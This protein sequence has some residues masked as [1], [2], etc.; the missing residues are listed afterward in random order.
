MKFAHLAD[1][2]LGF[3]QY[4]LYE[5][6]EDFYSVFN[7]AVEKII[8]ERPDFV[9]HSGDMFDVPR[10]PTKA[11][12]VLQESF[13]KLKEKNIP[14]YA[15]SGNHELIMRKNT[16]PPQVLYERFGVKLIN[17]E[18]NFYVHDGVFIGGCEYKS[19]YYSKQLKEQIEI[20]EKKALE[21]SKRILVLHQGID[22][23]LPYDFELKLSDLP[24]NFDYYAMGHIHRRI[25]MDYGRGLLVYPGSTELWKVD[26]YED[27]EKNGKGFALVEF[28]DVGSAGSAGSASGAGGVN[29]VPSVENIKLNPRREI[30]LK[31]IQ[32]SK[33]DEEINTILDLLDS[34]K[35]SGAK[36]E[37]PDKF[38]AE[39]EN[40]PMLYLNVSGENLNRTETHKKITEKI[41][42][43]VLDLRVKYKTSEILET[44]KFSKG[45]LSV[46]DLIN[47]H[48]RNSK[49][50][51]LSEFA[52][53]IF[54]QI[55]AGN[56]EKAKEIIEEKYREI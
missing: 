11:L 38:P 10:P 39:S 41:S 2:H 6:E 51:E 26:E 23:F 29:D 37:F 20:L 21:Y 7:E 19:K 45:A 54:N 34:I 43:K 17:S 24:E 8:A 14:V 27:F 33:L 3:R 28:N 4:G 50:P 12:L 42:G 16:L 56:T 15:V 52:F 31:E 46:K 55:S 30:I 1:T 9:I 5:R 47:E 40:K 18:K 53:E 35:I 13:A 36:T 25:T 44:M 48:F 22:V 49:T 32:A